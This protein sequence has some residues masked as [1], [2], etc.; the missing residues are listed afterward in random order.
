[1][2]ADPPS[3]TIL[4][5]STAAVWDIELAGL[6]STVGAVAAWAIPV[7]TS[8]AGRS[9]LKATTTDKTPRI[10]PFLMSFLLVSVEFS[11]Q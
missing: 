9:R 4:A 7:G 8:I 5:L 6:V 1:M 10:T 2:M 11:G 3:L